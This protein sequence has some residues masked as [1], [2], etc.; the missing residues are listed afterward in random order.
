MGVTRVEDWPQAPP[1]QTERLSLE[2][3]RVEHADEM[4]VVLGDPVLYGF[5]GGA[6]PT[7]DELRTSYR[8]RIEVGATDSQKRWL[9]WVMRD[10]GSGAAVGGMQGEVT[11]RTG[12]ALEGELA[13]IV[14]VEH[15]RRGYAREAAAAVVAWMR[16]T[17]DLRLMADIHPEHVASMAVARSLGLTQTD[18][19]VDGGELRW[20]E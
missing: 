10:R 20:R 6:P 16:E 7:L 14:G 3:L 18:E 1:L 17:G 19:V 15:Q 5:T 8:R 12:G 11:A 2:P 9:N 13:W 4:V